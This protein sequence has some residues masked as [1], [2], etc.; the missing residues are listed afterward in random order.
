MTSTK[1]ILIIRFSSIGDIVLTSPVI[2]CLKQQLSAE[3]HFLTKATYASIVQVNP[4]IDKV[5]KIKKEVKEVLKDLKAEQYDHIIDLHKNLRSLQVKL[6]LGAKASS[7][8]KINYEKWMMTNFKINKLPNAH[9]VDRYLKAVEFLGVKN[10]DKG[11][12]YYIP[13]E[14]EVDLGNY[15]LKNTLYIAITIG[16]AHATKCLPLHKIV[17]LCN[18]LEI[19]VVLIGGPDDMEVGEQIVQQTSGNPV[20]NLCGK[21]T[22]HQ[23]ASIVRQCHLVITPDTGMM[24]IAAAFRKPIVSIWGNTIPEFGMYPYYPKGMNRNQSFQ[25]ENLGCRPCSKI[26]YAACPKGHF[27]CMEEQNIMGM[28][29]GVKDFFK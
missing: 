9:I 16:A 5:F 29:R 25:V 12:D 1:K 6:A 28:I 22:L 24:H 2:R 23:S 7:F 3:I 20:I 14:K 18:G 10:D 4:N 15:Y 19:P 26:G 21:L 11:L 27:R 13:Q 17:E 8:D